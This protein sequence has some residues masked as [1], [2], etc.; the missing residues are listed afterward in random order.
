MKNIISILFALA[1]TISSAQ[2]SNAQFID[3]LTNFTF[4]RKSK[5]GESY[6][7][8]SKIYF[9]IVNKKLLGGNLKDYNSYDYNLGLFASMDEFGGFDISLG[10]SIAKWKSNN[11]GKAYY[12]DVGMYISLFPNEIINPFINGSLGLARKKLEFGESTDKSAHYWIKFGAGNEFNFNKSSFIQSLNLVKGYTN[13]DTDDGL[14]IE[15]RFMWELGIFRLHS[16]YDIK[17]T[18]N[19]STTHG[20]NFG[21]GFKREF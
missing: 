12:A 21:L 11:S 15:I 16:G 5:P 9:D 13:W 1:I 2:F 19:S 7:K 14:G 6:F 18:A 10:D 3:D 4:T 8:Q 20:Y 17:T